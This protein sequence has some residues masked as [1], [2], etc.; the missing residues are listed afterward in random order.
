MSDYLRS[1]A[2]NLQQN[3]ADPPNVSGWPAYYQIPQFYELW[4]NSDTLPKRNVFTDRFISTGYTRNGKKIVIDPIAYTSK[5]SKPEDPNI[6]LDEA[7]AHLYTID[8]SADVKKFL[9]SILLSNQVTDS[10]WTT[11]WL[12]YKAAPTTAKTA[13]VQTRLQEFYKYIMNLEE[14]Q[15]S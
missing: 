3:L 9:K 15:L 7:L 11:A 6:L 13:I 4:I 5:F 14:Y 2:S 12:D 10:Y 1:T 8:V